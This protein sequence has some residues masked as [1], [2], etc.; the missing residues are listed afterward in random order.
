MK[1]W[2]PSC[3][4]SALIL[5]SVLIAPARALEAEHNPAKP[6]LRVDSTPV[7]DGKTAVVTSYAEVVEPVQK[8]VVSVYST[9]IVA[10]RVAP[11]PMLRQL[12][13]DL[14]DQTREKKEEGL[15]SGVIVSAN[16]YIIT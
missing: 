15:G 1:S 5:G 4:L 2:S 12:F 3:F 16:G 9:K 13:G 6:E 10:Q 14:P 8:A 11:N 7:S